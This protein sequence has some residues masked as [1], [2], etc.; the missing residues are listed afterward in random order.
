MLK[1][2]MII[3]III[4]LVTPNSAYAKIRGESKVVSLKSKILD[5]KRE[6]LVHLPNNYQQN[7][8]VNYPVLYLLDGQRNLNHAAGTLDLLNQSN[9]AQEMIIVAIANTHRTRDLT[10]T[11]DESYN[12]WGLSGGADSFL[13]FIE[14]ELIPFVNKNYRTNN[15]KILS[16]HSL[17][18][19][20]SIYAL[21]SRPHLFQAHF[22]FSPSLWWHDQVIF[23]DAENFLA[24]TP[25]L[26]KYLYVNMGNEGGNMLSTFAR[27]TKLLKAHTPEGFSYN[28]DLDTAENHNT[29]ALV[30]QSLAYRYLYDTLQSPNEVIA[31]GLPAIEQF[32]KI[33]SEKYGY[34]IKPSYRAINSA[35]YNALKKKDFATAIKIF[36]ANVQTYPYRADA[37]DSLADGFEANGEL[38]KALE[39]R[40]FTIQKSISENVENNAYKTRHANLLKLIKEDKP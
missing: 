27:Y 1:H 35:G 32:F 39:M 37:Y 21:Q 9:M 22:A 28:S 26:N 30:G 11:Y 4:L 12:E 16:G 5:E 13:D 33:Q 25:K 10:P 36:E 2:A 3:F 15:F 6:L 14:Q 19:L 31:K 7:T 24:N 18:G 8:G 40:D 29:T 38:N 23:K 34:Q 20:L 17:G